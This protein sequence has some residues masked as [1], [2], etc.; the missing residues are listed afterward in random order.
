MKT[1]LEVRPTAFG[2]VPRIWEKLEAALTS[3]LASEPDEQRRRMVLGAIEL[4]RTVVALEQRGEPVPAELRQQRAM[5]E[6]IFAAIRARVGLDRARHFVTGAAPTPRDVLEFFHAIGMPIAD[7]WG[8]SEL[9]VVGTRNPR[10]RIKIGS[11]GVALPGV[12]LRLAPDGEL[13]VRGGMVMPGYYKDPDKTA[14]TIDAEGWLATGD[15]ATADADGYYT[16]VDRKKELIITAGGKNISPA[17]LESLLRT[18]A[19][20]GQ[21]CVI[22]D[23]RAYLTGLIVLDGQVAPGWAATHGPAGRAIAELAADPEVQAE[24]ARA[25]AAVNERVSR[26]ENIRRWTILPTEWTAETGELTPT[27]KLKRRVITERYANAISAMYS[28]SE[29]GVKEA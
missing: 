3:A 6:P 14:E 16:I 17:N 23:N 1:V 15:I 11:I 26:V 29:E 8:M 20:I 22:G 4:S 13:Q 2:S 27:F 25:V 21:A 10:D 28:R 7:V 5:A 24:V 18:H 19:L 9:A 12:E